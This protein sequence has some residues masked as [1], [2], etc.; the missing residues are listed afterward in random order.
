MIIKHYIVTYKNEDLLKKSLDFINM[1]KIPNDVHYEV[2]VIN[3]YGYLKPMPYNNFVGLNNILRLDS[4]T[5]H[6]ARNWNQAIMLGFENLIYPK[7]DIVILSQ[8][9]C[10]FQDGYLSKI[11]KAHEEYDFVQQGRGDE[12]HSYT[13]EHIKKVGIWDERFCGIGY[14]EIDYFYRSRIFNPDKVYENQFVKN[15]SLD[16][17][18]TSYLT[19]FIRKD[20]DHLKSFNLVHDYCLSFLLKKYGIKEKLKA[21]H[22]CYKLIDILNE[23][24]NLPLIETYT[25]YPYFEKDLYKETKDKLRYE[26]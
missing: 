23:K 24:V 4:S 20:E 13:V 17:V 18:D 2:N 12:Y 26:L 6:L 7:S 9:D 21:G 25:T 15:S 14:Q 19:G 8:G 10:F 16:I 11:I 3:N 1:Q 5:G 22:D